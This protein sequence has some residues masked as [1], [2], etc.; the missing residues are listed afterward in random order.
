MARDARGYLASFAAPFLRF[1]RKTELLSYLFLCLSKMPFIPPVPV[2]AAAAAGPGGKAAPPKGGDSVKERL[3]SNLKQLGKKSLLPTA[4]RGL[5][6]PRKK[7]PSSCGG[8]PEGLPASRSGESLSKTC[9]VRPRIKSRREETRFTLTLTPEAVLLLQRRN[10]NNNNHNHHHISGS[11]PDSRRFRRSPRPGASPSPRPHDRAAAL[12]STR[13]DVSS[14]VKVSL[15]NERHRYDD[16]EYED[17]E[18][19]GGRVDQRVMLKCTEWLRGLENTPIA[20][21][22]RQSPTVKSF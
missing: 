11:V 16:E 3:A 6:E 15:L 5:S 13:C 17:E 12:V 1:R 4:T 8:P 18:E 19:R 2:M 7:G 20:A 21:G 22:T 14:M 10:N 9:Q